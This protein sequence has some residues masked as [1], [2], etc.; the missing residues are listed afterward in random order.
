[1]T[2][3]YHSFR[4]G[5]NWWYVIVP[6]MFVVCVLFATLLY[7]LGVRRRDGRLRVKQSYKQLTQAFVAIP[8][9][10][11]AIW[12]IAAESW[13]GLIQ[14]FDNHLT[15]GDS[16]AWSVIMAAF[17]MSSIAILIFGL[18]YE[19]AF[20]LGRIIKCAL[21]RKQIK[22]ADLRAKIVPI[23]DPIIEDLESRNWDE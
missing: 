2:E 16:P 17:A 22:V 10:I 9:T 12:M 21:Y 6:L 11:I 18:Y 14:F 1:M 3:Y 7:R 15:D 23:P 8:L 20:N 5:F 19:V 13:N 4:A